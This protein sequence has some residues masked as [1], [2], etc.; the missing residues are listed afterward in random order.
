MSG[1]EYLAYPGKAVFTRVIS[2]LGNA[3]C[4]GLWSKSLM[5]KI[6]HLQRESFGSGTRHYFLDFN[7]AAN[8]S[9][10]IRITRSDMQ[11]DKTFKSTTIVVFEQDFHFLIESFSM[12]FANVIYKK[13]T[14][15]GVQADVR[16]KGIKSWEP[17]QRP[18]EKMIAKGQQALSDAELL[19][20]L[21]GSG[22]PDVTAVDLAEKILKSVGYDLTRLSKLSLAQLKK[23]NGIGNA[24][25]LSVISALELGR[26]KELAADTGFRLKLAK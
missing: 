9:D 17:E 15:A 13:E 24:K 25:A 18:R 21:I 8:N 22:T 1:I 6:Q 16:S 26:R 5:M 7:K 4:G 2:F 11:A 20:M 23:F 19:A 3:G 10:Y 14:E 12:L